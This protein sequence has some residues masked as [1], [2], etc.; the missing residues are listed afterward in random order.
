MKIARDADR[1]MLDQIAPDAGQR[2]DH[3]KAMLGEFVRRA[4][5]GAH[6]DGGRVD[7]AACEDQLPPLYDLRLA[8]RSNLRAGRARAHEQNTT[9]VGFGADGEILPRAH[10]RREVRHRAGHAPVVLV[11]RGRHRHHA[12]FP[13]AVL[14]RHDRQ[15]ALAQHVGDDLHEAGP[16]L[17]GIAPDGDRAVLA[18]IVAGEI[19]VA[20]EL[21][22]VGKHRG[23]IPARRAHLLPAVV[24]RRRAAVGDQSVDA[25]SATE[26]TRLLVARAP[27]AVRIVGRR[28]A[29]QHGQARPGEIRIEV[30]AARIAR[31][32]VG[33]RGLGGHI[34]AGF[35][36]QHAC[37]RILRQPR[38]EHATRGPAAKNH[39]VVHAPVPQKARQRRLPHRRALSRPRPCAKLADQPRKINR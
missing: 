20:F 10:G 11:D 19:E 30:G 4:D 26:N 1:G 5:T 18:V 27:A 33:G 2:R 7:R 32:H 21:A 31:Q 9:D 16:I 38:G 24:V 6:Q 36:E 34:L 29:E 22:E 12:V 13:L 35:D 25:R 3:A 14:V 17:R 37:A 23:E 15:A 39:V 8:R 28:V